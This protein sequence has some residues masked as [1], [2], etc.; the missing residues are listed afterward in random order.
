MNPLC[1]LKAVHGRHLISLNTTSIWARLTQ[2]SDCGLSRL[3]SDD[4]EP[5]VSQ[6]FLEHA[7]HQ[8]FIV[9]HQDDVLIVLSGK[10]MTCPLIVEFPQ[11]PCRTANYRT[12]P[13]R[14]K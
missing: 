14:S 3:Y 2:K 1:Q 6:D 9:N 8:V 7:A 4:V 12:V 13:R 10:L 11:F 5:A